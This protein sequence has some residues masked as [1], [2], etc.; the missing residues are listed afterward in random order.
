M[1]DNFVIVHIDVMESADKKALENPGGEDLMKH[2]NGAGLPF[3]AI[4]DA[5]GQKVADTNLDPGKQSNIGY[6][7]QP[8][9]IAHFMKMLKTAPRLS[10]TQRTQIETWLKE[11]APKSG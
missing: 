1:T 7:A 11:H 6:P 4:L 5:T 9:E 8:N 2:W 10:N 3:M